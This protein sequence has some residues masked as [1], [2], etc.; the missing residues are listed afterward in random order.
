MPYQFATGASGLTSFPVLLAPL[1]TV[2][3][4]VLEI[5]NF[6]PNKSHWVRAGYVEAVSLSDIGEVS[7]K[8]QLVTFGRTEIELEPP[9]YP[10]RLRFKPRDYVIK[11]QLEVFT[12]DRSGSDG[13]PSVPLL[14]GQTT[15][16]GWV[17]W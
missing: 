14:E 12:K 15:A 6:V 10:Y 13:S 11:W 2:P 16:I 7:S 17:V 4:L 9:A 3:K 1:I 8:A 5:K